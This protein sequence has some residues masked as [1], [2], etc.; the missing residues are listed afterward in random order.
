MSEIIEFIEDRLDEAVIAAEDVL[1][2]K[3]ITLE[4][5]DRLCNGIREIIKRHKD[6]PVLVEGPF[7]ME[8]DTDWGP[9]EPTNEYTMRMVRR[10]G[11]MTEQEFIKKFGTD[12][13]TAPLL[14]AIAIQWKTHPEFKPEWDVS[15]NKE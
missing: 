6:W 10:L 9:G 5:I 15:N 13:P 8:L 12:P 14:S 3:S 1:H 7:D 4:N 11:W 2:P